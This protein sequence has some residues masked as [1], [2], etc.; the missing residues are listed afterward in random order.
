MDGMPQWTFLTNHAL[1][2][3]CVARDPDLRLREI[4]D[5]VGVTE[6]AAHRIVGELVGAGYLTRTRIGRRNRYS[7]NTHLP[8][9][10]PVAQL[11]RVGDLLQVLA[12]EP[13]VGSA[14]ERD[15]G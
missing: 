15:A 11:K 6:R 1:V 7:V 9:P 12:G 4:G 10:D 3:L 14:G 13:A 2:L 8:L 5:E